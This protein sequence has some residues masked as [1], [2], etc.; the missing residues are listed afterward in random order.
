MRPLWGGAQR[1]WPGWSRAPEKSLCARAS[2]PNGQG[3]DPCSTEITGPSP[4]ARRGQQAGQHYRSGRSALHP[5][6]VPTWFQPGSNGWSSGLLA[7]GAA[8]ARLVARLFLAP[9]RPAARGGQCSTV[10]GYRQR[11]PAVW[12]APAE[13]NLR[14]L[15][16][17]WL[18]GAAEDFDAACARPNWACVARAIN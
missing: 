3:V 1:Q 8:V 7:A 12:R 14:L 13:L 4:L 5:G 15:L 11:V 17:P 2:V 9:C 10:V 18:L 6:L 16:V